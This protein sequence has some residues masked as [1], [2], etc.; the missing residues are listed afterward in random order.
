MSRF[1]ET[2]K[3]Q[4]GE[5]RR[6]PLHQSRFNQTREEVLGL[7]T[8]PDLSILISI[9]DTAMKGIHKCRIL[10]GHD[11]SQIEFTP[12]QEPRIH[13]LKVVESDS[14]NYAYKSADRRE[15]EL[16]FGQRESCDDILI[17]KEGRI[18]DSYF[19]NVVLWDG[20]QWVTP[21]EP[22]LK[23]CMR[24]SLINGGLIRER[25]IRINDLSR[26]KV[27]RLINA[28]NDL[29]NGPEISPDAISR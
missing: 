28:M 20:S 18:T 5:L 2:I 19:A 26:Y 24:A 16:L 7:K 23:G 11:I 12:Y 9:P 3:V 10:Y 15:L 21:K 27:L 1:I 29:G 22:L 17:V 14:I 25:D 13:S 6:L 8:H 4:N